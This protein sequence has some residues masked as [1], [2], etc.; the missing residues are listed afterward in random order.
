MARAT[1]NTEAMNALKPWAI[2]FYPLQREE[3]ILLRH[4]QLKDMEGVD[5]KQILM[6]LN[7]H[8]SRK[9]I[10]SSS[11]SRSQNDLPIVIIGLRRT[12]LG[13]Y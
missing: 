4:L 6:G 9:G 7:N 11:C 12:S 1:K 13:V 8:F 5:W 10:E 2:T 3:R